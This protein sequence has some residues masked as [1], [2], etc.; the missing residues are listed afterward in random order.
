MRSSAAQVVRQADRASARACAQRMEAGGGKES[1]GGG[2]RAG[3][4]HRHHCRAFAR[5]GRP[6]G[7]CEPSRVRAGVR[8]C[9]AEEQW[10]LQRA[11]SA[12]SGRSIERPWQ[13][14]RAQ[15][16]C[17]GQ[18]RA[19]GLFTQAPDARGRTARHGT[20]LGRWAGTGAG[21][22]GCPVRALA[23]LGGRRVRCSISKDA[24]G[25]HG[26]SR[27]SCHPNARTAGRYPPQECTCHS[28]W[29]SAS[30]MD[31]A[32]AGKPRMLRHDSACARV[33]PYSWQ[34]AGVGLARRSFRVD[35]GATRSSIRPPRWAS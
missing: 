10:R 32:A 8:A 26:R 9:T 30:M 18:R 24:L 35:C 33:V 27:A 13:E 15:R 4:A 11:P 31:P 14:Q 2:G 25:V 5:D 6:A 28:R 22:C 20:A 23:G 16:R 19:D 34:P 21:E 3:G 12:S 29:S 17:A 7:R 1:S